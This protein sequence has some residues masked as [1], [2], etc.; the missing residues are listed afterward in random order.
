VY[1]NFDFLHN[2][3]RLTPSYRTYG[4][5]GAAKFQLTKKLALSPRLEWMNDESGRVT[6]AAQR[7]KEFTLTGTYAFASRLSGWLEFRNDWSNQPFFNRGSQL[8]NWKTQPTLLVG[9]VAFVRPAK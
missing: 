6:G 7:L 3:P 5:A 8:G 9:V 4:L 2:S 1:L